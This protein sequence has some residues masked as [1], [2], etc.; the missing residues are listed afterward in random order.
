MRV[1]PACEL[2]CPKIASSCPEGCAELR[3]VAYDAGMMCR[4]AEDEVLGCSPA[5]RA[6]GSDDSCMVAPDGR[7]YIGPIGD[8]AVHLI[9]TENYTDCTQAQ[10]D[11]ASSTASVCP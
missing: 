11:A 7:L 5:G 2:A 10:V 8:V 1:P 6:H 3:A 4:A 9:A